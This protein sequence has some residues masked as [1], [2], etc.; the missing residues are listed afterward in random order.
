MVPVVRVDR[1]RELRLVFFQAASVPASSRHLLGLRREEPSGQTP[2]YSDIQGQKA[3]AG[4]CVL[5]SR[6][7]L[8]ST[9]L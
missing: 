6:M 8:H 1:T 2:S 3:V 5:D 7:S 9:P 4:R